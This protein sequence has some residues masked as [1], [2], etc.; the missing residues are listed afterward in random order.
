MF[1]TTQIVK[2]PSVE[3]LLKLWS[4]RY[5]TDLS[6]LSLL[7]KS[8]Q[9][10]FLTATSPEGRALTAA[11]LKMNRLSLNSQMAWIQ[12][13]LLYNY[14]PNVIDFSEAR[15]ITEVS[16]IVYDQ[17]LSIYQ[18]QSLTNDLPA[19]ELSQ[20]ANFNQE[21]F[22]TSWDLPEIEKLASAIEPTLIVFQK[23]HIVSKDW[24]AL[25]FLTT[26]LKFTNKLILHMLTPVEKVLLQPYL[27]FLE[28]QV[29]IPWQRICAAGEKQELGS[30]LLTLVGKMLLVI[31][32][33]TQTV[34]HQ[35]VT[36][37]PN[38]RSRSGSFNDPSVAHSSIRDLNMFQA[39]LW[40][41]VLEQSLA[42]VEE[43]LV[44]LCLM[45]TEKVEIKW[46][47]I[48]VWVQLLMDEVNKFLTL[49]EEM[50]LQPYTQG[51]VQA[52]NCPLPAS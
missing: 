9:A 48:S 39:Y 20:T 16:L 15:R 27:K 44:H 33:I 35:L 40:L 13:R 3:Y 52:F 34:Y 2:T 37:F 10:S 25:G 24:R 32:E 38:H 26:Q 11:K 14:I 43:E 19:L 6:S 41:C 12:T 23:Q 50:I 8:S 51:M 18:Q 42:P 5:K 21:I 46:E 29:A 7:E 30:P 4:L 36:M 47:L 17:L 28:E 22:F 49:E 1:K 45:V 31:E